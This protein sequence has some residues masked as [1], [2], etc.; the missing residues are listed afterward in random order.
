MGPMVWMTRPVLA[1]TLAMLLLIV[2]LL[3]P[4]LVPL[5][6]FAPLPVLLTTLWGGER[7]G[8]IGVS[9][10]VVAAVLLGG[11]IRFPL[12]SFL[13]FFG[14]PLLAAWLLR[15]GW[16]ITH[17]LAAAFLMG[18]AALTLLFVWLALAGI[19]AE[20][21]IAL[22]LAVFK[23][24]LMAAIAKKG[25]DAV[26]LA[27]VGASIDLLVRF[28]ALLLP[29][30]VVSGWYLLQAGN[31][32]TARQLIARWAPEGG[33]FPAEDL[34]EWRLPDLLVWPIIATGVC[35]YATQG[36]LRVLGANLFLL[37]SVPC[38]FQGMAVVQS[39][40]RHFAVG[41]FGRAVFYTALFFW[42]H[43]VPIVTALGL[44]D[45]WIDFRKRFFSLSKHGD[46]SPGSQ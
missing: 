46:G 5:Q 41:R 32:L 8:W 33:P 7:A 44:F 3:F 12:T 6:L 19:D 40:F 16:R 35:A 34:A 11:G 10:P 18:M 9:I 4:L 29:G 38:F 15:G 28:L 17:C 20:A 21:E 24:S 14:F 37:L 45:I 42:A 13:L 43:L 36:F 26:F 22:R 23:T 2:P 1:G 30:V 27:E 25:G 39:G 31:L